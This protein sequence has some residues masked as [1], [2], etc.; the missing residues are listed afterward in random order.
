[1]VWTSDT[2]LP[3]D[4]IFVSEVQN[5]LHWIEKFEKSQNPIWF[6]CGGQREGSK[7]RLKNSKRRGFTL[8]LK[9]AKKDCSYKEIDVTI[10][11]KDVEIYKMNGPTYSLLEHLPKETEWNMIFFSIFGSPLDPFQ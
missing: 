9:N 7:G 1:M 10:F 4:N 8:I 2:V 11:V 6:L 5:L 3:N